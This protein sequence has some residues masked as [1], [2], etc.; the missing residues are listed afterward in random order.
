MERLIQSLAGASDPT[1]EIDAATEQTLVR[2]MD[3]AQR[4]NPF[5]VIE[6]ARQAY[7]PWAREGEVRFDPAC[8]PARLEL[9]AALALASRIG[10]LS[11]LRDEAPPQA[12]AQFVS[13]VSPDLDRLLELTHLRAVISTDPTDRMGLIALL[14]RAKE[15]HMRETAYPEMA[16]KTVVQLFTGN[17]AVRSGLV[18]TAGF[19]VTDALEVL[20]AVHQLQ[21]ERLNERLRRMASTVRTAMDAVARDALDEGARAA[22]RAVLTNTWEPDEE[23]TTVGLP[24]LVA[25]TD[26]PEHR[27]SAILDR[28]SLNLDDRNPAEVLVAFAS[29]DNPWRARPIA[30][31]TDGRVMLPHNALTIDAVRQNLETALHGSPFW[32]AYAQHRGDLLESR[33][34]IALDRLLPGAQARHGFLY[35]VPDGDDELRLGEPLRYSK[36]VEG[37]HLYLVHDVAVIVED[38]AVAFSSQSRG[39]KVSRMRTDLTGIVTDASKQGARLRDAID[40]DGGVVI[41]GEGWVDLSHVREVHTVAVSL[42]DLS[43][44]TT[45]TAELMRAGLLRPDNIPWTVSLHDLELIVELVERPAEFLLYLRRRRAPHV[46]DMFSAPDELD[47]FICFFEEGLWVE[48]DPDQVRKAFPFLPE[49]TTAE[50]RRYRRQVPTFLTSRTDPVDRWFY[51]RSAP[52]PTRIAPKPRM[53]ASPLAELVDELA[54]RR[55]PGWLSIGSTLLGLATAAQHQM[56]RTARALLANPSPDGQGRSV[57]IPVTGST[58]S[59]DGWLLVWSTLPAA[60]DSVDEERQLRDYLQA[61]K[62]QLALPRGVVFLYEEA[63]GDLA[64]AFFDDHIGALPPD[65]LQRQRSL[66]S[67]NSMTHRPPPGARTA[68]GKH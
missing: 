7:L 1:A 44:V 52:D 18:S 43:N 40:R 38:K 8:S 14:V 36:R 24:E 37:D 31:T 23:A 3:G 39:G 56:A 53:V 6:V 22:V 13:E 15:V 26:V 55:V 46:T 57:T 65:L 4:F 47:L 9:L 51:S 35:Y 42:D 61:K 66:R 16:R 21:L 64:G 10:Q 19:D 20:T 68:R 12:I 11:A 48:P 30:R 60:C 49:P 2:V 58:E 50:R 67:A 32:A 33:T 29:G 63:T 27:V 34:R 62:H 25:A 28:F 5:R 45:A 41:E 59:R 54:R 17:D